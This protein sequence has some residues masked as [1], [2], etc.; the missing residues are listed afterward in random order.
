M[1]EVTAYM[2]ESGLK[3]RNQCLRTTLTEY[4]A[5]HGDLMNLFPQ[6][7][8]FHPPELSEVNKS[9]ISQTGLASLAE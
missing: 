4:I 8:N 6:N 1:S 9:S 2:S 3:P 7:C 5:V